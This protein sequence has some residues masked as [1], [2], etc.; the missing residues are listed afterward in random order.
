MLIEV[1]IE[2]FQSDPF[3]EYETRSYVVD[4]QTTKSPKNKMGNIGFI[5]I[6]LTKY[7]RIL[8]VVDSISGSICVTQI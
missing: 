2:F 4:E 8:L 7:A 5:L 6:D 3:R 1:Q